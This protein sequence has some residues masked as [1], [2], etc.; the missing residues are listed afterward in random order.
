MVDEME[1]TPVPEV[2]PP[3]GDQPLLEQP[4]A[5]AEEQVEPEEGN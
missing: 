3:S 2:E 1:E 4:D 5:A